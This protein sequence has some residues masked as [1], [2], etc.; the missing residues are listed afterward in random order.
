MY[1]SLEPLY[2][3][4]REGACNSHVLRAILFLLYFRQL[5]HVRVYPSQHKQTQVNVHVDC[6]LHSNKCETNMDIG[7]QVI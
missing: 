5:H 2:D 6:K 3:P 7:Y 4:E 1:I